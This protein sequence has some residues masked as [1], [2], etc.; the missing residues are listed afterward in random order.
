MV[1]LSYSIRKLS[2][3]TDLASRALLSQ[4][5]SRKLLPSKDCSKYAENDGF[6][7]I[8]S[9]RGMNQDNEAYRSLSKVEADDN[10]DSSLPSETDD[11]SHDDSDTP[12]LSAHQESLKLLEQDLEANPRAVRKWLALLSQT[13]STI[14]LTSKNATKARSEITVSIIARALSAD[15][16]NNLDRHLRLTYLRAGEDIWHESKLRSEWEDALKVGGVDIQLEWLEWKIRNGNKGIDGILESAARA[17]TSLGIGEEADI[18]KVRI[19]W[20]VAVAIKNAGMVSNSTDTE[21]SIHF[22]SR[23]LRACNGNVPSAGRIVLQFYHY[24][25]G[26]LMA[27]I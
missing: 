14:P 26:D 25:R 17:L 9:R 2:G 12:V 7:R 8:P 11:D 16:Q 18:G 21:V 10:S 20:R 6:I 3:L 1:F 19:F 5:P 15:P 23:I 13:L 27:T 4:P 24:C 22:V